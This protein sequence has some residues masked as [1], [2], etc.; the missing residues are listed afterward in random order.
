MPSK[1]ISHDGETVVVSELS[2]EELLNLWDDV[3]LDMPF[4]IYDLGMKRYKESRIVAEM[5]E[6]FVY[7][8]Q[9]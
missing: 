2:D 4:N 9:P 1:A 6:R 7:Q 5:A 8:N 3:G